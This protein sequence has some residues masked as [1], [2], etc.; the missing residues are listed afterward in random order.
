MFFSVLLFLL[1]ISIHQHRTSNRKRCFDSRQPSMKTLFTSRDLGV[2]ASDCDSEELN[3]KIIVKKSK[4]PLKL[5]LI[6]E[7]YLGC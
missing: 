1:D 3:L 7:T 4:H 5:S 6:V 2:T